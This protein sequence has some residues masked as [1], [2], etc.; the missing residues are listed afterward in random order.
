MSDEPTVDSP[1]ICAYILDGKGG[2]TAIDWQDVQQMD[3]EDQPLWLHFDCNS[4]LTTQWLREHSQLDGF[5][6]EGLLASETRPRCNRYRD[7]VLLNLRGVNMNPG[8]DPE[9]MVSIRIWVEDNRII[10]TRFRKLMAIQDIRDQ[11]GRGEGPVSTWHFVARLSDQLTDRISPVIEILGDEIAQL[12][13]SMVEE[14]S[15]TSLPEQRR[16]LAQI[17]RMAISLR[18][19]IAPQREAI[20]K[21]LLI[22]KI[23]ESE[24]LRGR[25]HET[26]DQ[27][28]RIIEALDDA[29]ERATLV[30]DELSNRMSLR[31]ERTM[32]VLTVVASIM[33]PLGFLTGLLGINVGGIPGTENPMAFWIVCILLAI[34]VALEVVLFRKLKW[35]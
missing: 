33:L 23:G 30:Q 17:R 21:L 25:F 15:T 22:E 4:P 10:S 35:I 34:T 7:G 5:A 11:W 20:G 28:T 14:D 16:N 13:D 18:R 27:I 26:L 3:S 29:R 12:E 32:Y 9:D 6:I 31:M 1:L 24:Q 8:Q 2:A 19:Y